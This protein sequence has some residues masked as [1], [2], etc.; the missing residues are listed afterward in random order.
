MRRHVAFTLTCRKR[1]VVQIRT[2]L[3]QHLNKLQDYPLQQMK[4]RVYIPA[5]S[6]FGSTI[7]LEPRCIS[8]LVRQ[9]D[10]SM[11]HLASGVWQES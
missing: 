11:R 7:I 2:Q 6:M 3:A 9:N 8:F 10:A 1:P 4:M 5:L